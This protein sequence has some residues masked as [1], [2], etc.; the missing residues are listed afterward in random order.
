MEVAPGIHRI[1]APLGDRYVAL[2][3][4]V[5]DDAALLVDS[6]I[7]ESIPTTLLPY[8]PHI[9][10]P[11]ERIRFALGTHGDFDH[12]GGNAALRHAVPDVVLMCGEDDRSL[13]N[14]VDR[15]ITERYGEFAAEHGFDETDESRAYI[16]SVTH[17]ARVD[18][19]L[20]GGERFDLGGR[21]V[22]IL[23]TPGHSHGHVSVHDS[24][25]DALMIGDAVLGSS[26]LT[27]A[28]APAF[29]PTYRH[30]DSYR[31]TIARMAAMAPAQLLCSHYPVYRGGAAGDF[32]A[33]SLAYT[34]RVDHAVLRTLQAAE[35]PL[36][37]LDLVAEVRPALG[38]WAPGPAQLLVYPLLGHLEALEQR[39][40][41]RRGHHEASGRACFTITAAGT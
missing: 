32:L 25:T 3:L 13:V 12:I 31:A 37:L 15:I 34:D 36:T 23:H 19:G 41:V 17:T 38:T 5:G 10:L 20:R 28:G 35:S 30:V 21:V 14:H 40:M 9:G 7:T 4:V 39:G 16:R 22:H 1:E 18:V 6:G 27:A 11:A 33:E 8:L 2:Y 29:P 24:A 26:V